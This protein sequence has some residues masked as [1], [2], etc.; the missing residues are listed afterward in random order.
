[1]S[2]INLA[3]WLTA[4]RS[5]VDT[6]LDARL[7]L[8]SPDPGRLVEAMRYSL[9]APGKRLRPILALAAMEAVGA[10]VDEPMRIA[11][12]SVEL[13]HVFFGRLAR[14]DVVLPSWIA[15]AGAQVG[16]VSAMRSP[17][18]TGIVVASGN[19]DVSPKY[20]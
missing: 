7:P 4:K 17:F 9:L 12:A 18:S 15:S 1:M 20:G 13:V 2:G 14:H 3:A 10:S 8:P 19:W 6:L 5:E 16:T 11:A